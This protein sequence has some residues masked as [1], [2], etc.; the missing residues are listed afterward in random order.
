LFIE[1]FRRLSESMTGRPPTDDPIA[2]IRACGLGYRQFA[3]ENQTLYS[4]MF[5]RVVP[6]FTPSEQAIALAN[7]TLRALADRLERAMQA[8]VLRDADPLQTAALVWATSHGVMSLE[9]KHAT[10]SPIDWPAVYDAALTM[11]IK[12]LA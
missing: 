6:D 10:P 12:G 1:G 2:D 8:G 4:V 5:E 11:I 9:L 3:I 7:S